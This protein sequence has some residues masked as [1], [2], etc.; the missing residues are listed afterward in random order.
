MELY[1]KPQIDEGEDRKQV[2]FGGVRAT[3]FIKDIVAGR[4]VDGKKYQFDDE[5]IME[6]HDRVSMAPGIKSFLRQTDSTTIGGEPVRAHF[7]SLPFKM[8]LFGRWLGE[9]MDL[10]KRDP[11][12][13]TQALLVAAAAHYGL[14]FPGFHPFD[15]GN[16]RTARAL[17][18]AILMSQS[19]E[20]TAHGLAI[21]PVPIVRTDKD[22]GHYIR[23]L[24]TIDQSRQL[25][26]LMTFIAQRWIESLDERLDKI[27]SN[28]K[29]PKTNADKL[30]IQK[31]EKRRELLRDFV[32]L[33]IPEDKKSNGNDHSGN[34]NSH[35]NG[36][37]Y[38]V[39]PVPDYFSPK[40][41]KVDNA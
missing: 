5:L 4:A 36:Q 30:L 29:A 32:K 27:H 23:A 34:G 10:I 8:K 40:Y 26:P 12:N 20:L 25:N 33:G 17:M 35:G 2:L 39:F 37:K 6:I 41:V 16:G 14:V 7:E 1:P 28:I 38:Q 11:E 31:L 21:P 9:Q 13:L 19:Y 24:R 22:S 18:N 3:S 15:N